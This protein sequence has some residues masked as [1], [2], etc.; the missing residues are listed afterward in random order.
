MKHH[1]QTMSE[2]TSIGIGVDE[3][4][5]ADMAR[6][7]RL[8]PKLRLAPARRNDPFVIAGLDPA[9]HSTLQQVEQLHGYAGQARV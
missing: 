6:P 2:T 9:I 7:P 1:G 5:V 8:E 4:R 3:D